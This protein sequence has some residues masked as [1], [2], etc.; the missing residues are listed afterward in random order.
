MVG[1][2]SSEQRRELGV[3]LR[4]RREALTPAT[5]GLPAGGRRR[6]PGLRREEVA[7]LGGVSST[8]YTWI[9][10][11]RDVQASP[12]A[13]ARLAHVLRLSR[14]ERAYLFELAGR[15]DPDP[16]AGAEGEVPAAVAACV[17]V[18]DAPA[19]I[20]DRA[21]NARVCNAQAAHLFVGWLDGAGE[22]NLLRFVFLEPAARS[23]IADWPDR[24]RRLV[25][26]FRAANGTRLDA[27]DLRDLVGDLRA[28]SADFTRFWEAHGVLAREGGA[29]SFQHP[30]DGALRFEQAT[31]EVSGR[32]DLKLTILTPAP[33]DETG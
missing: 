18:I 3:F 30:V 1:V 31:F 25:A 6:T 26:E 13:L 21:W 12:Q 28:R 17:A 27:P 22:R 2:P 9:E 8:W 11:G 15:R 7:Q 33:A 19:Y 20:L 16:S 5:L 23:L 29:R 14:A 10:Q 4:A 24:A 32:P